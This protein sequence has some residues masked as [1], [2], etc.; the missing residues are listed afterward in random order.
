MRRFDWRCLAV[1]VAVGGLSGCGEKG[2]P[3]CTV[4]GTVTCGGQ[5]VEEGFVIFENSAKGWTRSAKLN[6]NGSYQHR[7]VPVAEYVV[8]V[9]PPDPKLPDETSGFRGG[10]VA[11]PM[12]DPKNIP[13]KFRTSQ[14]TPLRANVVEG[15]SR[16]DFEL[17]R[18]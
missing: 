2:P 17:G 14:S 3:L 12:P 10:P 5:A 6:A 8:R 4:Q 1:F 18:E 9:V 16:C 11:P 7:E 15:T 13:R